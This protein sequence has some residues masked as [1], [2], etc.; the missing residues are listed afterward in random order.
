MAD[1][2]ERAADGLEALVGVLQRRE[3]LIRRERQEAELRE[4]RERAGCDAGEPRRPPYLET[5]LR[6]GLAAAFVRVVPAEFWARALDGDEARVSCPCGETPAAL[7]GTT[8]T[9]VCERCYLYDGAQVRVAFSPLD[10]SE[11]E[12]EPTPA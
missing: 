3:E 5:V 12:Q 10:E 11:T 2:W 1:A 9:C 6:R 8:K 7:A 4:R